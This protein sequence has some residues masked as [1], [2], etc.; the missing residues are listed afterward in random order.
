MNTLLAGFLAVVTTVTVGAGVNLKATD[1]VKKE[2]KNTPKV[3]AE[4]YI[5]NDYH[6]EYHYY[7]DDDNEDNE[8]LEKIELEIN[9]IKTES[10]INKDNA[11]YYKKLLEDEKTQQEKIKTGQLVDTRTSAKTPWVGPKTHLCP[12]SAGW[13]AICLDVFRLVRHILHI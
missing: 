5:E 10:K 9:N 8:R 2:I 3:K 12:Y 13:P 4:T 6:K 1:D 7:T 11:N